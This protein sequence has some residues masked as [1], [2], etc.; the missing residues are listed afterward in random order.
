M[1]KSKVREDFKFLFGYIW[2]FWEQTLNE[3]Y[4]KLTLTS[5]RSEV[6]TKCKK[7]SNTE[8]CLDMLILHRLYENNSVE[9]T[10][11][12]MD[13]SD[14]LMKDL[15][16]PYKTASGR[17]KFLLTPKLKKA[18]REFIPDCTECFSSLPYTVTKKIV[19]HICND[20]KCYFILKKTF[21][22]VD[23]IGY[24]YSAYVDKLGTFVS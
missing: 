5:L 11:V 17:V 19:N 23:K 20:S 3:R 22:F 21:T 10:K 2:Q 13:I 4:R 7:I 18:A 12:T 8:L 15:F 9:A 24:M 6:D 16:L 14:Q 1:S